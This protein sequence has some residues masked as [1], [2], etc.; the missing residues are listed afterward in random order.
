MSRQSSVRT[1]I[2][3]LTHRIS[4]KAF[5]VSDRLATCLVKTLASYIT[6]KREV[7]ESLL[8]NHCVVFNFRD[9]S[10]SAEGGGFRPVEICLLR[11]ADGD[12]Q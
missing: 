2:G 6:L 12:W 1:Q 9:K 8:S 10:Y 4:G 3:F 5:P 7:A 11:S